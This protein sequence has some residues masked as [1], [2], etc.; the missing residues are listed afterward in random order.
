MRSVTPATGRATP[1]QMTKPN[2]TPI[3]AKRLF[4]FGAV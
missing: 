1:D 3:G 4:L 2:F